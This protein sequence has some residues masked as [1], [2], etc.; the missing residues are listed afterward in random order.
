MSQIT[1]AKKVERIISVVLESGTDTLTVE[2]DSY[3]HGRYRITAKAVD[4]SA[5]LL[6]DLLR[7][8]QPQENECPPRE[9]TLQA[10]IDEMQKRRDSKNESWGKNKGNPAPMSI[11]F[12]L[13]SDEV[14]AVMAVL[15]GGDMDYDV[16]S[17]LRK[18]LAVESDW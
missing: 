7:F 10:V 9:I 5:T 16:T 17:T 11:E 13:D 18:A 12:W 8:A 14:K 4:H 6:D 2:E 1:A 15:K 3:N